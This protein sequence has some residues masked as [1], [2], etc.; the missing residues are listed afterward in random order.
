MV[1][2]R[3]KKPSQLRRIFFHR[4]TSRLR[5]SRVV[6]AAAANLLDHFFS[7]SFAHP[8]SH[9]HTYSHTH[10]HSNPPPAS[11]SLARTIVLNHLFLSFL[12][13]NYRAYPLSQSLFHMYTRILNTL[14]LDL[15]CIT[16][17]LMHSH[18]HAHTRTHTHTHA[19]TRT[20]TL[21][22]AS[23]PL[24]ISL[25]SQRILSFSVIFFFSVWFR[26]SLLR[27]QPKIKPASHRICIS[28]N[29]SSNISNSN[30]NI[31]SNINYNRTKSFRTLFNI[32]SSLES[33]FCP[34]SRF[35]FSSERWRPQH[36]RPSIPCVP[37]RP[38]SFPKMSWI[39]SPKSSRSTKL[40]S[41]KQPSIRR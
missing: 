11:H 14:P 28:S 27:H 39:A 37:R 22:L 17:T 21:A 6:A 26:K 15:L 8:L 30:I 10:T 25:V 2:E 24:P 32:F 13:T 34:R 33:R 35:F 5:W 4:K 16:H 41:G 7:F 3:P 36:R 40:D 31:S 23:P 29:I 9:I 19:H 18:P 20:H 1:F 12:P 38:P